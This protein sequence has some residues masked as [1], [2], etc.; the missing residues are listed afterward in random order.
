MFGEVIFGGTIQDAFAK[1]EA[2]FTFQVAA[3]QV[4]FTVRI[5]H[6]LVYC[7]GSVVRALG[8]GSPL[9]ADRNHCAVRLLSE[10]GAKNTDEMM[11]DNC[12]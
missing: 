9:D 4:S 6:V 7:L 3:K 12:S 8:D 1:I 11:V 10:R 5:G 2:Q